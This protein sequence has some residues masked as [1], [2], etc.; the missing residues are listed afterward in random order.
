MVA[1]LLEDG[2]LAT[3]ALIPHPDMVNGGAPLLLFRCSCQINQRESYGSQGVQE[4]A[5]RSEIQNSK[6]QRHM[7]F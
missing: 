3:L 2:N 1:D 7:I 5:L 4:L 6:A